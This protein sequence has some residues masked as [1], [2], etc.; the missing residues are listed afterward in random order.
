MNPDRQQELETSEHTNY[1]SERKKEDAFPD[2][3]RDVCKNIPDKVETYFSRE[4][5]GNKKLATDSFDNL[6][7]IFSLENDI[8]NLFKICQGYISNNVRMQKSYKKA[9]GEWGIASIIPASIS[10]IASAGIAP[11]M[12]TSIPPIAPAGMLASS[13]IASIRK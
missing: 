12:S 7:D 5:V 6:W 9:D 1:V 3:L 13:D 2:N 10:P 11:I 4:K 8:T